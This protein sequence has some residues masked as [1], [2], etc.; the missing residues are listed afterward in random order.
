MYKVYTERHTVVQYRILVDVL[1]SCVNFLQT[2]KN[3]A[4]VTRY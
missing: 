4:G 2:A 3:T 1:I